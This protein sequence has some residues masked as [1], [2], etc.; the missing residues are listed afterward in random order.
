MEKDLL[1]ILHKMFFEKKSQNLN[2]LWWSFF[3]DKAAS[4]YTV[5]LL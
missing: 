1:G 2:Q 3:S 5:A 4:S